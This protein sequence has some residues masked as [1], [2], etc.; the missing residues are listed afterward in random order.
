[1]RLIPLALTIALACS[2]TLTATAERPPNIVAIVTDD[3]AQWAV[4]AYGNTD[5]HTPHTDRLAREGALFSNAFVCTP[6]CSP[7]RATY[8][9]GRWPTQVGITDY[10]TPEEGAA[11][12]GL[13][14][15]TWPQ[16]LQSQGYRTGLFGK[17]HLGTQP[18]FHPTGRGFDVFAGFLG[19][20]NTPMNPTL[21][22]DGH[23]AQLPGPL[24]DI[25]TDHAIRFLRNSQQSSFLICLH[26][27][28]PH[29]PYGPVP[30]EDRAHYLQAEPELPQV[31]GL[32]PQHLKRETLAYYASISSIDRNVGRLLTALDELHLS[33]STLVLFTSDHGYNLGRHL[34]DTKGN[35]N[36]MAG[37]VR[38]PK[39][40]NMWDTSLRVPLLIRWPGVISP[41]T[42]IDNVVTN[43][44]MYRTMAGVTAT[45]L[46]GDCQADGIDFSPLLRGHPIPPRDAIFGQYDLH[47]DGLAYMRMVRTAQ[48]KL[49]R[50]FKAN[51]MDEL[52]DLQQDPDELQNLNFARLTDQQREAHQALQARLLEW[53]QSIGDP[54]SANAID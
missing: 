51:R 46:P 37:G 15:P 25:L 19:G 38:G 12:L 8:F 40:P 20:G 2:L 43:L 54:L 33:E 16:L 44:D 39:R 21:E 7:S 35:G 17:W 11:G 9:S 26:F 10:L 42:R 52:Y 31:K 1:M 36:W 30:A 22:V 45:P 27:R 14:A 5:I 47:N 3:Q 6:V 4:G 48:Y 53:Q 23:E 13:D 18:K 32:D 41:G 49:V 34:I 50:H 28:A 29:L 24:P